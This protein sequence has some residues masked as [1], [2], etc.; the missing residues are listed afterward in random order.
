[1]AL[2]LALSLSFAV[3]PSL[4][5]ETSTYYVSGSGSDSNP[6]TFGQPWRTIDHAD[7]VASAGDTVYL[8][9]GTYGARGAQTIIDA[10]GTKAAPISWLGYPGDLRPT[11]LGQLHV[12][13]SDNRIAG[14]L[15]EGPSGSIGGAENVLVWLEARGAVFDHNEVRNGEG[16]AGVY[17]SE[18]PEF[19]INHNY[20]HDNGVTYNLDHGIYVSSGSGRIANNLIVDNYAWGVQLYP[21]AEGVT[22]SGNTIVGN[23][24]GGVVVGV[25]ATANVVTDNIIADNGEYGVYAYD[26]T[27]SANVV[28]ENLLWNQTLDTAGDGISFGENT[29]ADPQFV[30]ES[31]FRLQSD[32]P[33]LAIGAGSTV[34]NELKG[35]PSPP[36][37]P[38]EAAPEE[39]AS[40]PEEET[41]PTEPAPP[42]E[43][44]IRHRYHHYWR[45]WH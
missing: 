4:A 35:A 5:A 25:D 23:G 45:W 32:S 12:T 29:V 7:Q 1:M 18:A 43:A 27:G 21:E 17:V 6:G 9:A 26:L 41:A 22:V 37:A 10:T 11:V 30:S 44:P 15:F 36:A 40:A 38:E 8:R 24:R 39:E 19:S 20:I 16:H 31:D 34:A 42:E 28:A 14:L 3:A 33:A 13:G 2:V